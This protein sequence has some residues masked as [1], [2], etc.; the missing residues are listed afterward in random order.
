MPERRSRTS[1]RIAPYNDA[2]GEPPRTADIIARQRCRS[3]PRNAAARLPAFGYTSETLQF[4][5][6]RW[7]AST[8]IP[9]ARLGNDSAVAVLSDKPRMLYAYFRPL[10]AQVTNPPIDSIRE[11]V[12]MSLECYIGPRATCSRARRACR[13]L[14]AT[15][16][17]LTND[18]LRHP[19]LKH[20]GWKSFDGNSRSSGRVRRAACRA[21]DRIC[22]EAERAI[23]EG[24]SLVVL[25]DR[26]SSDRVPSR[27][28][29]RAERHHHLC[30][31]GE[32]YAHRSHLETGEARGFIT[33]AC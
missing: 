2:R 25:S 32:A 28:C 14:T 17:I 9:S 15:P 4:C 12:I 11:E 18:E 29:S 27:V 21:I 16:A 10:F 24:Y 23:D 20:R 26:A 22:A 1:S 31:P 6:S 8:A 19:Q 33:I 13:A 30:E 7:C 5:C 3:R